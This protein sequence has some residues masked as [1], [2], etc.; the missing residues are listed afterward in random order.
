MDDRQRDYLNTVPTSAAGIIERAFTKTAPK[1]NA[2][3]AKC[4]SCTNFERAEVRNCPVT[5]CPLH[6]YR[7]FQ[8]KVGTGAE[9]PLDEGY[10]P[11]LDGPADT[12]ENEDDDDL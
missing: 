3:K 7:P 4:L 9:A 1:S 5:I 2:I 10:D 6:A 12:P 8:V 11:D